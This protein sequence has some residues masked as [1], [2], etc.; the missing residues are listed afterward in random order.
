MIDDVGIFRTTLGVSSL[1]TP[2]VRRDL[3]NVLVD[4]GS[5]YTWIP[6][7]VLVELGVV[8]CASIASR[9][10]TAGPGLLSSSLRARATW[11]C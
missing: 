7:D 4:T 5:E 1:A 8:P 9:R 2:K 10:P 3:P 6:S 11:C